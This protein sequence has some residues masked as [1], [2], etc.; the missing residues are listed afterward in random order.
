MSKK[1]F[2]AAQPSSHRASA[3]WSAFAALLVLAAAPALAQ[4]S[5]SVSAASLTAEVSSVAQSY[6]GDPAIC[7]ATDQ[8]DVTATVTPSYFPVGTTTQTGIVESGCH[9]CT[10]FNTLTQD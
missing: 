7:A 3:C 2:I 6:D 10:E 8:V 4:P 5:V 1:R 9:S